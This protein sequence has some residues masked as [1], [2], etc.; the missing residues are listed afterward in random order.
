M[1]IVV[2]VLAEEFHVR[3]DRG[4]NRISH[5]VCCPRPVDA[6]AIAQ[7]DRELVQVRHRSGNLLARRQRH[8]DLALRAAG[9]QHVFFQLQSLVAVREPRQVAPR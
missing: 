6:A 3:I 8:R 7:R 1:N 2:C 4:L 9:I 5:P